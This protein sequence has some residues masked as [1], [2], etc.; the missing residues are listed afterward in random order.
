MRYDAALE[1]FHQAGPFGVPEL[2]AR[3]GIS[4][5]TL[6]RLLSGA[7]P[8]ADDL[9]ELALAAGWELDIDLRALTAPLAAVA[10]RHLLGDESVLPWAADSEAWQ[11]RLRRFVEARPRN[12]REV[13]LVD[14]AGRASS[15]AVRPGARHLRGDH[16]K[17]DR[18]VSA[19]RASHQRWALSG[20]AALDALG[21][22]L[23][24]HAPTIM[25][26][27]NAH[28]M[29]QLLR[30]TFQPARSGSADLIVIPAHPSIFAGAGVVFDVELVS[31][32][33]AFVDAAGLGGDARDQALIHFGRT[34]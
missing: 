16:W 33:Q 1:V 27:E 9:E 18:L 6:Y 13:A 19:G 8:R 22:D 23:D 2:A 17:V 3:A 5:P 7:V 28:A 32:L 34:A 31:P 10:V 4:R 20:W 15:P 21:L 29:E 26:V 11:E 24:A 25:W 30:D 12:D 14:E